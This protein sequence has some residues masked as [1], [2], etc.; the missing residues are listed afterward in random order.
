MKTLKNTISRIFSISFRRFFLC[1]DAV[2]K[3][4]KKNKTTIFF[5]MLFCYIRYGAGYLDYLTFG[6]GG[7]KSKS[8]KTFMCMNYN[9]ALVRAMNPVEFRYL[10]DNKDEFNRLFFDLLGREWIDLRTC[11]E[12]EF[13]NFVRCKK[14]FFSKPTDQF[15]GKGILHI[16]VDKAGDLSLLYKELVD[17][18]KYIVE[19]KIVQHSKMNMLS[20]SSVNSLRITTLKRNETV[21]ILYS[22]VRM[23][24]GYNAVDN[25]S[26]GGMYCPVSENG[27]ISAEAFCDNTIEYYSVHPKTGTVFLGFQIPFYKQAI[28]LVTEAA[29][30]VE[31]LRYIGWDVA[32]T[33]N[34]PVLIEGNV[35]PGYDMCQNHLHLKNREE[36]ILPKVKEILGSEN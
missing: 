7:L 6:F 10:L 13:I 8:R 35:I 25:I 34:G 30:R 4:Y 21:H 12:E 33:E 23:S 28:G 20:D 2:N 19:Q 17:T 11:T 24:D 32:I 5:D 1:I 3:E 9:L 29:K 27:E 36:G 14:E 16:D 31:E 22:I 15:G 18:G 26:S